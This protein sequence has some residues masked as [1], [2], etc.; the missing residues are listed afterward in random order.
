MF[1]RRR[2]EQRRQA[3]VVALGPTEKGARQTGRRDV[4]YRFKLDLDGK[5]VEHAERMPALKSPLLGDVVPVLVS[6]DRVRIVWDD[7]PDIAARARAS[8]AAAQADD[9]AGAAAALGF[10]LRDGQDDLGIPMAR[11]SE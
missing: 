2:D 6:G 11:P 5:L 1:G 8:A 9:A 4:E 3:R 10:T 7:V